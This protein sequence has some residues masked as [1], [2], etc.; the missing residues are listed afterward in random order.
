M[1]FLKAHPRPMAGGLTP[2]KE[3]PKQHNRN[4]KCF[5]YQGVG[6]ISSQC[7]NRHTMILLDN[8]EIVT[9]DE[10]DYVDMPPLIEENEDE[11]EE[12]ATDDQIGFS[13]VARRVLTTQAEVDEV[14]QE[15]IFYTCCHVKDKA[16]HLI[17]DVV[18]VQML[19]MH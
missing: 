18:V 19:P 4:I 10:S 11:V 2:S 5:K 7:P 9:D 12:M 17:I 15:N 14:Q 6:H 13:L 3:D 8:G 16:S 1:H